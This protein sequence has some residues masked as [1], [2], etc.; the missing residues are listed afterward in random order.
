M[1]QTGFF[2]RSLAT[3]TVRTR[4]VFYETNPYTDF[5]SSGSLVTR[6]LDGMA[7]DET[8]AWTDAPGN[9]YR[10]MTDGLGSER[11][12]F[13]EWG[14]TV[15][16]TGYDTFGNKISTTGIARRFGFTGRKLDA[17]QNLYYYRA[18][19]YD[20]MTG[21]FVSKDPIGFETDDMTDIGM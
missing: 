14:T 3:S 18:R 10:Y 1:T 17:G 20:P 15:S 16:H 7:V 9:T 19:F 11:D 21:R 12:I 6:Y 8:L 2:A 13:D 4:T 5:V